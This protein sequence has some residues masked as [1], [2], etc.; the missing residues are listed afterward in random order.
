MKEILL[1]KITAWIQTNNDITSQNLR[2]YRKQMHLTILSITYYYC[3]VGRHFRRL[4]NAL[5]WKFFNFK[6]RIA[7]KIVLVSSI[8]KLS[9]VEWHCIDRTAHALTYYWGW[10]EI[11]INL[12]RELRRKLEMRFVRWGSCD[13]CDA[14]M[15]KFGVS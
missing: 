12:S 13:Q 1:T 2:I 15:G 5:H 8:L 7:L 10:A 9:I 14:T 4:I 11:L 6:I 3:Y